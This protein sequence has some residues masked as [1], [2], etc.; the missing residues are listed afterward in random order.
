MWSYSLTTVICK[1]HSNAKRQGIDILLLGIVQKEV[2]RQSQ[3]SDIYSA[4]D[5]IVIVNMIKENV[6]NSKYTTQD[7]H[8]W[9][10]SRGWRMETNDDA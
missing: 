10:Y 6:W 3:I 8:Q 5:G 1:L 4:W 2:T 7:S 9:K